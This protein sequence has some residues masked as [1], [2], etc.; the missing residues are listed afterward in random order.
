[1]IGSVRFGNAYFWDSYLIATWAVVIVG[2]GIIAV[3]PADGVTM[4]GILFMASAWRLLANWNGGHSGSAALVVT[5][6]Y[7][8]ICVL[9]AMNGQMHYYRYPYVG[10]TLPAIILST[11]WTALSDSLRN[12]ICCR[13]GRPNR[14]GAILVRK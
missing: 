1:M 12:R 3:F 6:P 2:A 7:V 5:L 4:V 10:A 14:R 8:A 11:L 13:N 9:F